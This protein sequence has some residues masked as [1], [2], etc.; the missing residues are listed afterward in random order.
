M[1]AGTYV[2]V[3]DPRATKIGRAQ[4]PS[5]R[6]SREGHQR[7]QLNRKGKNTRNAAPAFAAPSP[8]QARHRHLETGDTINL[9]EN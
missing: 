2:F 9:F 3:V 1:E 7:Q 6:P 4:R 5:S 8:T